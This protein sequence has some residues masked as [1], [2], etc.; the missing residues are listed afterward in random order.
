VR[1]QA[2]QARP[3]G[4]VPVRD[5]EL[6]IRFLDIGQGDAILIRIGDKT[7]LV[8]AGPANRIVPRLRTL[9]V[10]HIDLLVASHNHAD[11]IGGMDAVLDSIP[12]LAYLDNGHPAA[13]RIQRRVLERVE[14]LGITYLRPDRRTIGLEDAR[15]SVLPAPPVT[16][17]DEQNNRSLILRVERGSFHALLPGDAETQ[18]LKAISDEEIVRDVT[19]LKA[20]H[21][22]S[23]NGVTPL[24]LA[25]TRP[26]H[27]VISVGASNIYGHPHPS[28]LRYY[29]AGGRQLLRTDL[30]GDVIVSVTADGS[31]EI[32]TERAR[33]A[34]PPFSSDREACSNQPGEALLADP[35][36]AS[37]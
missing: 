25:R 11:H 26:R 18:L 3:E 28:A 15:I 33:R 1:A 9:G 36:A 23:R 24:W 27:V 8:D 37:P 20:S 5:P 19:L 16:G 34:N 4:D 10:D 30:H 13:T 21:H 17:G 29:C 6:E 7:V 12:V 32:T 31:Y 22:G 35:T 2:Q 14:R